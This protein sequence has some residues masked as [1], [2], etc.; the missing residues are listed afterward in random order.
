MNRDGIAYVKEL[1]ESEEQ[2]TLPRT[3]AEQVWML[4]MGT[5]DD[6][7]EYL[8]AVMTTNARYSEAWQIAADLVRSM[9]ITGVA[10]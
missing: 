5:R 9:G 4:L 6:L 10:A 1:L 8:T 7:L 3:I 2:G